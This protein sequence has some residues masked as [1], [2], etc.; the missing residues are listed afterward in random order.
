MDREEVVGINQA[1]LLLVVLVMIHLQVHRKEIMEVLVNLIQLL[2][3][4][5][6]EERLK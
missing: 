4:P 3:D 5:V 2:E 1:L 6:E